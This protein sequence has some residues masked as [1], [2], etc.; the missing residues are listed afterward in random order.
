[1]QGERL[2]KCKNGKD[3]STLK[4]SE[5]D[6]AK[7]P[8]WGKAVPPGHVINAHCMYKHEKI[9]LGLNIRCNLSK[10]KEQEKRNSTIRKEKSF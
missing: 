10:K 3:S 7:A 9:S 1:M 8:I 5:K 4:K 6:M 2:H